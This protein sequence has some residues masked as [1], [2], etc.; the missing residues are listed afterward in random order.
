MLNF[1]TFISIVLKYD[2]SESFLCDHVQVSKIR[3]KTWSVDSAVCTRQQTGGGFVPVYDRVF[4]KQVKSL[5]VYNCNILTHLFLFSYQIV[6]HFFSV[7]IDL[8]F[9][10]S[11]NTFAV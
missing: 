4:H 7:I 8:D 9:R 10:I 11:L 6:S 2:F 3:G 5:K 1:C